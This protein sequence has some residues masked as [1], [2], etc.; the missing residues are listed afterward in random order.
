M[1]KTKYVRLNVSCIVE[2]SEETDRVPANLPELAYEGVVSALR[3]VGV[4]ERDKGKLHVVYVCPGARF[5]AA[6]AKPPTVRK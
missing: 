2:L 5:G 3:I 1:K 4:H 6:L